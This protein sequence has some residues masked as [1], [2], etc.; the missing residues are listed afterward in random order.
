[1]Y[2]LA[3]NL[4]YAVF[5]YLTLTVFVK[6]Y[7]PEDV[8]IFHYANAFVLPLALA[9]DLQL[10]SLYVTGKEDGHYLS[11][12]RYRGFLNALTVLIVAGS[13][14]IWEKEVFWYILV[15]GLMKVIENQTNLIYGLYQK[16]DSLK[17]AA[18]S[19]WL[20]SGG[21]FMILLIISIT[22]KPD[23]LTLLWFYLGSAV[24]A[25]L[26]FDFRWSVKLRRPLEDIRLPMK[27]LVKLTVPMFFI[28]LL[29]KYY[30]NYPRLAIEEYFGLKVLGVIGTLFYIRMI[31]SQI[32]VALSTAVQSRY[33]ELI[34]VSDASGL[35]KLV[36]RNV[37][38]GLL[39][40]LLLL[41]FFFLTGQW[42]LPVL[43]TE[44]FTAYT[45]ELYWILLGS[46]V[47]F[48]Y[49]FFGGAF[50]ALRIH[51]WKVPSRGIAFGVLIVAI[52]LFH[53]SVAQVLID[54][55]IAEAVLLIIYLVLFL[56][57]FNRAFRKL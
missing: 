21:S 1:M 20:R 37:G 22:W 52:I 23:F 31:G 14:Y 9:F 4:G 51:Q 53:D 15:L 6:I 33:A 48:A 49:T 46:S 5:Q 16:R 3:G 27:T 7:S 34:K 28:A 8:G 38:A 44:E 54:I 24:L 29:E 40:G 41:L 10:R 32:V 47:S 19:R 11:Y 43:F 56:V 45:E 36:F 30:T 55:L 17:R 18:V 42:V 35:K 2:A 13:A 12:L 25:F 26:C 50:N 39:V 57:G